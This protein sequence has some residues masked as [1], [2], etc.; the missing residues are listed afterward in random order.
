MGLTGLIYRAGKDTQKRFEL[1]GANPYISQ[2][3]VLIRLLKKARYTIFG[4]E[5]NFNRIL[6]AGDKVST[7]QQ[8]VPIQ[9]Y[10]TISRW[11]K[12]S[13]EGERSV[14]W[15]GKV[16][17]FALSSGTSEGSSKYIPVTD[18]MLKA[19]QR[20][21]LKQISALV[22]CNIPVN[23][24][25]RDILMLGGNSNLEN[26]GIYYAGDLSG[27]T[28][29]RLPFWF[30]PFYKPGKEISK[31]KDWQEK[32]E[33]VTREACN[34]DVGAIA[35]VPSWLQ[36]LLE[37]VIEFYRVR[38]IHDVWPNLQIFVHGGVS[39]DS[40]RNSF[41]TLLGQPLIYLETYL[42]SEGFIAYQAHPEDEGMRLLTRNGIFFEFIPFNNRNFDYNG[43]LKTD[44]QA[45]TVN[46]VAEGIDYA[47]VLSTCA[48]AWR[49][50]IGDV[51]RFIDREKLELKITGRTKHFISL[52]GEHLS[53]DN[54]NQAIRKVSNQLDVKVKEF[55][56]SGIPYGNYFAHRWYISTEEP[57]ENALLFKEKLDNAL[58]EVNDDYRTERDHFLKDIQLELI[59]LEY[60]L[61][62]LKKQGKEGAQVKFPRVLKGSQYQDWKQFVEK[63]MKGSLLY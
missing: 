40:Y 32:L 9:T 17:H 55:T 16:S 57:V 49:Y 41:E 47:I 33:R 58:K 22:H 12:M 50:L 19:I 10:E 42:A 63:R 62:W 3:K 24:I 5:Y 23:F 38:H 1:R 51:V 21:G 14:A 43:D 35:G 25:Q 20:A 29:G 53:V 30:R 37:K 36:L 8:Q 39:F 45:I 26:N 11:W 2:Q 56:V 13:L 28:T 44:A 7:L 60:F 46:E 61:D 15:P 52:C 6:A 27:I 4:R 48:G 31:T 18:A 34:W 59:P 54:M